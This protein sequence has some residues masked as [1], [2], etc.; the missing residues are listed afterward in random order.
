MNS[1]TDAQRKRI[2]S[3]EEEME[4]LRS[5]IEQSNQN[6]MNLN[7]D[8][9]RKKFTLGVAESQL[10]DEKKTVDSHNVKLQTLE[11]EIHSLKKKGNDRAVQKKKLNEDIQTAQQELKLKQQNFT[12][13]TKKLKKLSRSHAELMKQKEIDAEEKHAME[14]QRDFLKTEVNILGSQVCTKCLGG[15][16]TYFPDIQTST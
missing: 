4:S 16:S 14:E 6:L 2:E 11:L 9:K 15:F 13:I 12:D 3:E 5:L 1:S 8:I 7:D 10:K